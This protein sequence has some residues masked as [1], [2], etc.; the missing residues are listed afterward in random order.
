MKVGSIFVKL[1]SSLFIL[2]FGLLCLTTTVFL[3]AKNMTSQ[4]NISNYI[5]TANIF[6][7]PI[8]DVI[9]SEKSETLRQTITK[10]M[11]EMDVPALVVDEVIDSNELYQISY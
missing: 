11:F 3:L 4:E 10:E 9:A 8:R 5:K 2:V 1:I 6:D 7:Y